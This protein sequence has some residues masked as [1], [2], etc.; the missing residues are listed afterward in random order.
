MRHGKKIFMF[1]GQGTQYFSMGRPLYEDHR[2]F[3]R[4]MNQVEVVARDLIGDSIVQ[5]LY[6][7]GRKKSD[8]F[9]NIRLT[10]PALFAVQWALAETLIDA[11]V[12]PD[13]TLG[14]SL[15]SFVAAAV[16]GCLTLEDAVAAV[17]HQASIVERYCCPGTLIAIFAN[18]HVLDAEGLSDICVIVSRD[19]PTHFVVAAEQRNARTIEEV[20]RRRAL[21]SQRLS[22]AFAF[23][24]QWIDEARVPFEN[25]LRQLVFREATVPV[26]SSLEPAILQALPAGYFWHVM[27]QPIR[28]D[29]AI[30]WLE[31]RGY[32]RY[33]DL[34]PSGSAATFLKYCLSSTSLSRATSILSPFGQDVRNLS[35]VIEEHRMVA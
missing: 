19:S 29:A 25:C 30:S 34:G 32:Y 23:H 12:V 26:V 11:D 27:R 18:P 3:R 6:Y 28:L 35:K 15:G 21:T 22:V 1:S 7:D 33:I 13:L 17:V 2:A 4:R 31:A 20:L 24:S 9:D 14:T 8:V 10:H 16:S 5:A